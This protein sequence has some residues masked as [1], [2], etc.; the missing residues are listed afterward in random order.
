MAPLAP[1]AALRPATAAT[2]DE[3]R[4][5]YGVPERFVLYVGTVEPRKDV[6]MLAEAC[7]SLDVPLVIAGGAFGPQAPLVG[8]VQR[9]G[10]VPAADLPALYGLAEVVGYPSLYEGFGLPPVEALACGAA[11]VCS[12]VAD[13]PRVL[14][15]GAAFFEPG[16]LPGLTCALNDVWH[17]E[18]LR[19]HLVTR[20]Q[21]AVGRL[22]WA[23]T[24]AIT[25]DVYASLA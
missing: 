18:A 23:T 8:K 10:F 1:P 14:G 3:V 13:L 2:M 12:R 6:R 22:S 4:R 15:E 19:N 21:A 7:R 24:A 17:D 11:L 16:D 20:G 9:L 5:R 25:A